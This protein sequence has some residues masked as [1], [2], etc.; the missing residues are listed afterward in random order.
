[1]PKS[2][3]IDRRILWTFGLVT[4]LA[5]ILIGRL[6]DLQIIQHE[7]FSTRAHENRIDFAPLPPVRGLIYDRNGEILAENIPIYSLEITSS[8]VKD[9]D[10]L[11]AKLGQII[12]LKEQDLSRFRELVARQP[13]FKRHTL[14][15]NLN[16]KEAALIALDQ[17]LYPGMSL[18]AGVQR[19]YP[20]GEISAHVVGYV[21]RISPDDLKKIN[22]ANYQGLEYIGRS[23]IE[24]Q[25]ESILRGEPGL[26]WVETDAHGRPVE[27][28]KQVKSPEPGRSIYINLDIHLQ[29]KSMELLRGYKGAIV[30]MVPDTGEI[31]AFASSPSFNP[32]LF[33][34]GI[35]NE[36]YAFLKDSGEQPLLNRALSGQYSPG[37]T[38]KSFMTLIGIENKVDLDAKITCPGWYRL[39]N[40][41]RRYRDWKEEG[42]GSVDAMDS[43]IQSCDVYFYQ[44]AEQLGIKNIHDGLLQLGFGKSTGIDL[45]TGT[46]GLVPSAEWKRNTHQEMWHPGETI[47]VGIG[48]GYLL[49]TPLQLAA[50]TAILSNKG[51]HVTPRFLSAIE[52]IRTRTKKVIP[53]GNDHTEKFGNEEAYEYVIAA[54]HDVVHGKKGTA[55]G[56]SYGI[57]YKMAGKTGTS[58][59]KS[60]PQGE[61]YNEEEVEY[62][63]RDHSLFIAFA[64]I[65]EPKIAIAVIAEHAGSGSRIAAP[66]ARKVLDYYLLDRLKMFDKKVT[67]VQK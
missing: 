4:L 55:R 50:S 48:Q 16:E 29:Q 2:T 62:K 21:G 46:E 43:I 44:L 59:V 67:T 13:K 26:Q 28:L 35:S 14:R 32:N 53:I 9:M 31:L 64:P 11:L 33:V 45:P 24:M 66:I 7:K 37:S 56:I 57:R 15:A 65:D 51:K 6:V 61:H 18:Q 3:I 12:E 30:A 23:G 25:Y 52:N 60:I 20:Y 49:T 22:L 19:Y 42:H 58:Q 63:F 54:M 8:S 38:I 47:I 34:N 10:V 5:V 27:I 40:F 41:K 39:S 36:D 17:H 1:M